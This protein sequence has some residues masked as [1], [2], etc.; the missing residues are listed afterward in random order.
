MARTLPTYDSDF[1]DL[2]FKR[3]LHG[4]VSLW[5]CSLILASEVAQAEVLGALHAGSA[6]RTKATRYIS[7]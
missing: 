1:R 5:E 3:V 4:L 7:A 6:P 2:I